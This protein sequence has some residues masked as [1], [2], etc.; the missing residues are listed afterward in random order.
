[1]AYLQ[2]LNNDYYIKVYK[3]SVGTPLNKTQQGA[4]D[5]TYEAQLPE[6]IDDVIAIELVEW[7]LPSDII[8]TFYPTTTQV[9]GNNKLDFTLTNTDI[10]G[11]AGSFTVTFPTKYYMYENYNDPNR[12]YNVIVAKLMNEAIDANPTWAGKVRITLV[13]QAFYNTL[14]IVSTVGSGL[15]TS[16]TTTL[17]L[18][19]ATGAN[20][21]TSSYK[22]MGWTSK[23]DVT[24][25]AS[26]LSLPVGSQAISSP[27]IVQLRVA[28]FLDVY[29]LE[30]P[31]KPMARIFFTEV[32]YI[33]NEYATEAIAGF[34]IDKDNPPR[35]LDKLNIRLRYQNDLDPGAFS[36]GEIIAPHYFTFHIISLK[37]E[38]SSKPKW[39]R[40]SLAY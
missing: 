16:S 17:R 9:A 27:S 24:S 34:E 7:S 19:F 37:N 2:P 4:S 36:D 40:Q 11:T 35:R 3:T 38:I 32:A 31:Q 28:L 29:V 23:V 8:P 10:S 18:L 1:M 14:F 26:L 12:D 21:A 5:F 15:P 20:S 39:V 13:P 33:Q 25:S 30:S 6:V 22:V